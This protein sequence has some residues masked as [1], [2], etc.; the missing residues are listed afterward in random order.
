MKNNRKASYHSGVV[1]RAL[2]ATPHTAV[3]FSMHGIGGVEAQSLI[4]FEHCASKYLMQ[5][6]HWKLMLF[7]AKCISKLVSVAGP[8]RLDRGTS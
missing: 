4:S 6:E 8:L 7:S 2:C 3:A 5:E 1:S